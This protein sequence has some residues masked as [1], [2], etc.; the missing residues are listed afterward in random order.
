MSWKS[1]GFLVCAFAFIA[2]ST[3]SGVT[4]GNEGGAC[5]PNGTCNQGLVCLSF[6][7]V[8]PG[9][10]DLGAGADGPRDKSDIG[11]EDLAFG[12]QRVSPA[13]RGVSDQGVLPADQGVLPADQGVLPADQGVLPADQG[14]L[15]ADQRVVAPDTMQ[16]D[17]LSPRPDQT[18]TCTRNEQCDDGRV[19]TND[20]CSVTGCVNLLKGGWCQIG[21]KCYPSGEKQ[22][23]NS[24]MECDPV[25]SEKSWSMSADGARCNDGNLCTKDDKCST[26]RCGGTSYSCSDLYQRSL[27]WNRQLR[28]SGHGQQLL[29]RQHL[30]SGHDIGVLFGLF[31]ELR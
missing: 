18:A 12:D 27:R 3:D 7:C 8:K 26:G 13:D 19:C 11:S 10:N 1:V 21:G 17:T 4:V 5:Y 20:F 23:G 6:L 28:P 31:V 14:V 22:P 25:R 9:G 2:C 29:D 24:C 15:P 16:P 30:V